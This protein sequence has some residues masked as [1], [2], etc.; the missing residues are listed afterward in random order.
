MPRMVTP[1]V[2]ILVLLTCSR[3]IAANDNLSLCLDTAIKLEARGRVGDK[4]LIAAHQACIRSR[5]G[6]PDAATRAKV[7]VATTIIVDEYRRRA[8][9]RR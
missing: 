6:A 9:S 3:A 8:G 7:G 1:F 2:M 5:A 4:N